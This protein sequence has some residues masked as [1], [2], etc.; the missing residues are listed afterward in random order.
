VDND[1]TAKLDGDVVRFRVG[2][3]GIAIAELAQFAA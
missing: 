2:A 3:D 1:G